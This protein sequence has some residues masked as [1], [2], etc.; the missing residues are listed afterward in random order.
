MF[1]ALG[2]ANSGNSRSRSRVKEGSRTAAKAPQATLQ[3]LQSAK[4]LL[5]FQSVYL[6]GESYWI[7]TRFS[8]LRASSSSYGQLGCINSW[9]SSPG[10]FDE[11]SPAVM[12]S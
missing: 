6:S 8:S 12:A 2:C 1:F 9:P 3:W 7:I 4:Q 10:V 11:Q 5:R